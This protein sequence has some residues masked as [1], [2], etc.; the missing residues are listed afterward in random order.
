MLSR[1]TTWT[2]SRD[3]TVGLEFAPTV[4]YDG[5]GIMVSADSGIETLKDFQGKSI[6][7][8]AGT[9]TE[10]NLTKNLGK[11]KYLGRN[12]NISASRSSLCCL[13]RR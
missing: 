9:T 12:I 6:W 5:Q 11:L 8:E 1:N 13:C 3:T 7:V 4:F 2:L 10:L